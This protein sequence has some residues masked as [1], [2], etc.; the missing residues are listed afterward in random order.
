MHPCFSLDSGSGLSNRDTTKIE[1]SAL[2]QQ[3]PYRRSSIRE[4]ALPAMLVVWF[5]F[6]LRALLRLCTRW[7]DGA[8]YFLTL[9]DYYLPR[10]LLLGGGGGGGFW[11]LN[12]IF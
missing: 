11:G 2:V 6:R 3:S 4:L 1:S 10:L 12:G 8:Y 9:G 7:G 5:G